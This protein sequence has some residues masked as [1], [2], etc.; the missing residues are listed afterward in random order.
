MPGGSFT[1]VSW[2][3]DPTEFG[4]D[5]TWTAQGGSAVAGVVLFD[6]P[7]ARVLDDVMATDYL[8][9]FSTATWPTVAD[10][11]TVTIGAVQYLVRQ[12][13]PLDDGQLVRAALKRLS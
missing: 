3:F 5:A 7:G 1:D 4:T 10:R 13:M 9:T 12:V 2:A 6:A 11:D 8:I